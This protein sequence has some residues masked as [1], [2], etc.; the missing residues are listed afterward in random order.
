MYLHEFVRTY[1]HVALYQFIP[2]PLTLMRRPHR[3]DMKDTP[4]HWMESQINSHFA[5]LAVCVC[6]CVCVC[7]LMH[8]QKVCTYND[9]LDSTHKLPA[10]ATL[11]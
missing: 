10:K 9:G 2:P 1:I 4:V 11:N 3:T 7:V 5:Q 8:T 6:V